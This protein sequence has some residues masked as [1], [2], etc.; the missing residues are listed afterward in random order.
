MKKKYLLLSLLC[1]SSLG[2]SQDFKID[3]EGVDPLNNLPAGVTHVHASGDIVVVNN[4]DPNKG[5]NNLVNISQVNSE[6]IVDASNSE[7]KVLLMDYQGYLVLDE[8]ALGTESFTVGGYYDPTDNTGQ[9]T[10]FMTIAGN[11]GASWNRYQLIQKY[12]NGTMD[13]IANLRGANDKMNFVIAEDNTIT[14]ESVAGA[15]VVTDDGGS[16]FNPETRT[17]TLNYSFESNGTTYV[18]NDVLEFR[19]RVVDGVN[20]IGI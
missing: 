12:A 3:F 2:F 9:F 6:V 1:I 20:Q 16:F 4:Q 8:T 7:N 17:I 19:N 11:N 13:G 15:V 5:D 10:G 14:I 18:A